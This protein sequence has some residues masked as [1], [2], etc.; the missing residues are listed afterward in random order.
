MAFVRRIQCISILLLIIVSH[1]MT[2]VHAASHAQAE[3]SE[4]ELCATYA[5]PSEAV[6]TAEVSLPAVATGFL[7]CQCPNRALIRLAIF[8]V[9]PR[10]PP[11]SI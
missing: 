6:P 7:S 2:A 11:L 9:H 3:L 1:S 4:C 8:S 5:D 10:G